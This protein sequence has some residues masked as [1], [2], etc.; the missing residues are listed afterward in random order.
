M[1]VT[2]GSLNKIQNSFTFSAFPYLEVIVI[3]DNSLHSIT[4]L[5]IDNLPE[6]KYLFINSIFL[7][8]RSVTL[9]NLPKLTTFKV[10]IAAFLY[11]VTL[12]LSNLPEFSLFTLRR[13]SFR[14]ISSVNV[15]NVPFTNGRIE[16]ALSDCDHG[17]SFA[18]LCRQ[19]LHV[20]SST[21]GIVHI[22]VDS[23]HFK[24]VFF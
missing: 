19:N 5:S 23:A 10:G 2:T 16:K 1:I 15:S 4:S 14:F 17:P 24:E 11:A 21:V 6:L 20:D 12:T 13:D 22:F 8:L 9:S 3:Q 7:S 18:S